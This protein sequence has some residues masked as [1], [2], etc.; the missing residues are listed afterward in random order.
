MNSHNVHTYVLKY[1]FKGAIYL[2]L[3]VADWCGTKF[4]QY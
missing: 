3:L 4:L 1:I 2:E